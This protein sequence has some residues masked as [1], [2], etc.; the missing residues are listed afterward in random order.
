M[1]KASSTSHVSRDGEGLS[2]DIHHLAI[3]DCGGGW[4]QMWMV[5]GEARRGILRLGLVLS[6]EPFQL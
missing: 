5:A 1:P 3:D 4:L 6:Q 2:S